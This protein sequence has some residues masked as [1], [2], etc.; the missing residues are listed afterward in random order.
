MRA[1]LSGIFICSWR[2]PV[3]NAIG[4][5][6]GSRAEMPSELSSRTVAALGRERVGREVSA[7][8]R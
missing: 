6:P 1:G 4:M 8:I 3:F 2:P 7:S 5:D